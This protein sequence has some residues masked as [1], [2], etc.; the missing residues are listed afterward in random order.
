MVH[1]S[2]EITIASNIKTFEQLPLI[3]KNLSRAVNFK[4]KPNEFQFV[5]YFN[6]FY[7]E[8]NTLNLS[9]L[10]I[11]YMNITF[12]KIVKTWS[13]DVKNSRILNHDHENKNSINLTREIFLLRHTCIVKLIRR[14]KNER[15]PK[16]LSPLSTK[17]T[18]IPIFAL[19]R[20]GRRNE[21]EG[22]GKVNYRYVEISPLQVVDPS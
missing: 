14:P 20:G 12:D 7:N 3:Q 8:Q 4:N 10:Y 5:L 21:G 22:A 9:I 6:L 13:N 16:W 18:N 11:L 15:S 17:K 2:M 1:N 19:Q